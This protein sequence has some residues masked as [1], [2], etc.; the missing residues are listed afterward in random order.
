MARLIGAPPGYVGYEEGGQLTEAVR[1]KPYCVIL[2]DEVEKAHQGVLDILPQILEEGRL[3]LKLTARAKS[4]LA[5]EDYDPVYGARPLRRAVQKYVMDPLAR[6]LLDGTLT[7]GQ[8]V[9]VDHRPTAP[10]DGRH[11]H[12]DRNGAAQLSF[13]AS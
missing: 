11:P 8:T 12:A 7:P 13:T 2:F 1:R 3:T 10:G 9:T 6:R 4:F 5:N